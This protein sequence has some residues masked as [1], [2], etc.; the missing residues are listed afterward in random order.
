MVARTDRHNNPIALSN[1]K[2]AWLDALIK[3]KI[4]Y[5]LGDKFPNSNLKTLRFPTIAI[6]QEAA[7]VALAYTDAFYWYRGHTGKDILREHNIK[8]PKD[9]SKQERGIQNII[10]NDIYRHE[11]GDGRLLI[12]DTENELVRVPGTGG[13]YFQKN[14]TTK[15][16]KINRHNIG[17]ALLTI[18]DRKFGSRKMSEKEIKATYVKTDEFF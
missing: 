18:F 8:T 4:A 6:G 5:S 17:K 12:K 15:I 16:Q 1:A 3:Y 10:I 13:F 9:F 2:G 7:R 11:T 14:G